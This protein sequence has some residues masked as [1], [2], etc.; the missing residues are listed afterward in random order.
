MG[1]SGGADGKVC[2]WNFCEYR[3]VKELSG[4]TGI[5]FSVAC[6]CMDNVLYLV[7]GS[8]DRTVILWDPVLYVPRLTLSYHTDLVWTVIVA[9]I[10]KLHNKP[11]VFSGSRDRTVVCWCAESGE[12]LKVFSGAHTAGISAIAVCDDRH[13]PKSSLLIT[14]GN[15]NLVIVWDMQTAKVLHKLAAHTWPVVGVACYFPDGFCEALIISAGFD[16]MIIVWDTS[17]KKV[18]R[19][20]QTESILRGVCLVGPKNGDM[21]VIMAGDVNGNVFVF[22]LF[23]GKLK[24]KMLTAPGLKCIAAVDNKEA[25]GPVILTCGA[26]GCI[27]V[28][29][30][31]A[32]D[33]MHNIRSAH[34]TDLCACA[35]YLPPSTDFCKTSVVATASFGAKKIIVWDCQGHRKSNLSGGHTD[36]VVSMVFNSPRVNEPLLLMSGGWDALIIVWDVYAGTMVKVLSGHDFRIQGLSYARSWDGNKQYLISGAAV[37]SKDSNCAF[38]VWNMNTLELVYSE[39]PSIKL[40]HSV[41][42]YAPSPDFYPKDT[43]WSSSSF[44][45]I[46]SLDSTN[47]IALDLDS[48]AKMVLSAS[49]TDATNVQLVMTVFEYKAKNVTYLIGGGHSNNILIW[50]LLTGDIVYDMSGHE[51]SIFTLSSFCNPNYNNGMP[52]LVSGSAD[53]TIKLWDLNT[54]QLVQTRYNHRGKLIHVAAKVVEGSYFPFLGSV[55]VNKVFYIHDMSYTCNMMGPRGYVAQCFE[56]DRLGN[57]GKWSRIE[58]ISRRFGKS[59]WLENSFIIVFSVWY[60]DISFTV[61]FKDEIRHCICCTRPTVGGQSLLQYIVA[62][63][64]IILMKLVLSFWADQLNEPIKDYADQHFFHLSYFIQVEDLLLLARSYPAE[65][66]EFVCSIRLRPAHSSLNPKF[67]RYNMGRTDIIIGTCLQRETRCL[68]DSTL[69]P[70]QT[71][72]GQPISVLFLPLIGATDS[73]MLQAYCDVCIKLGNVD[74]FNHDV[75]IVSLRQVWRAYGKKIHLRSF[76]KYIVFTILYAIAVFSY[77]FCLHYSFSS[78]LV[79]LLLQAATLAMVLLY[80]RE[81]WLQYRYEKSSVYSHV[82]GDMWNAVDL[83]SFLCTFTGIVVRLA[84]L[85]D[86]TVSRCILAFASVLIWF[87][88]LYFLRAFSSSGPLGN[89]NFVYYY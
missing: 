29:D 44:I 35:W 24:R 55:C 13:N 33:Q 58:R 60:K 87:K 4:H 41:Y 45:A 71:D 32:R 16:K 61:K 85:R 9:N 17:A 59:F 72:N 51:D 77:D 83:F 7:S 42:L 37:K 14:G 38:S 84:C 2:I 27:N 70:Q 66:S 52:L 20:I 81:E 31:A 68:W 89:L 79:G 78:V 47:I 25:L 82:L 19:S 56:L 46:I 1:L 62:Y 76:V 12:M 63:G 10:P 40:I 22:D 5:V 57:D 48:K 67:Y 34:K 65:F 18:A 28:F 3:L 8:E 11:M 69:D 36:H 88:V 74:I 23:T 73:R 54:G 49:T 6:E 26:E 21:P 15:D 39:T 50:N 43:I 64:S 75:G 53:T 80:L 86:T 30:L